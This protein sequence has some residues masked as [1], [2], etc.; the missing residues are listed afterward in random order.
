MNYSIGLGLQDTCLGETIVE[1]ETESILSTEH[2]ILA[3]VTM[4]C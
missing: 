1:L 3:T 4:S 2:V